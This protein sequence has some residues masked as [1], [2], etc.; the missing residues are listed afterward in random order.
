MAGWLA[1]A[2]WLTSSGWLALAGWLTLVDWLAGWLT[3]RPTT[4]M[5]ASRLTSLWI[6]S[7]TRWVLVVYGVKLWGFNRCH[8]KCLRNK[9]TLETYKNHRPTSGRSELLKSCT[10]SIMNFHMVYLSTIPQNNAPS[11]GNQSAILIKILHWRL[12]MAQTTRMSLMS[13]YILGN[14][15]HMQH[16]LR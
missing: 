16:H 4:Y 2:G 9:N 7:Q 8:S 12:H 15:D 14:M 1:L 3:A 11:L 6:A 5:P 13:I 10:T